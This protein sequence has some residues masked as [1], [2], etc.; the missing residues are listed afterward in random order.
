[1]TLAARERFNTWLGQ[2]AGH[3]VNSAA[4]IALEDM[5]RENHDE[6]NQ[7]RISAVEETMGNAF[8]RQ[9]EEK[10]K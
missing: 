4:I 8:R 6:M 10:L 2:F 3:L 1:M 5:L 7:I 9:T